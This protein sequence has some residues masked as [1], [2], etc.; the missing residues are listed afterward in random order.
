VDRVFVPS[1]EK[2]V[3]AACAN[4]PLGG[5][6]VTDVRVDFY[7]GKKHPVDS[8]DIA[9]QVARKAAFNEAFVVARPKLLEPMMELRIRVPQD[10]VGNV[11]ADVSAR[12][13]RILGMQTEGRFELIVAHVPQAELHHYSSQLRAM[14]SGRGRHREAFDH[15]EEVPQELV[16]GILEKHGRNHRNGD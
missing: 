6:P 14:S 3:L 4:G 10:V 11:M 9:F 13:G 15:F 16:A 2:G 1:V 8:K 5:F 7:D 12:R